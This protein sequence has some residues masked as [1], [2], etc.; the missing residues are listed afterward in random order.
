VSVTAN[1][2]WQPPTDVEQALYEAKSRGDWPGYLDVLGNT[3][4]YYAVERGPLDAVGQRAF[5]SYWNEQTRSYCRSVFTAGM[6][7]A[8]VADPVYVTRSLVALA[9]D[10]PDE[11]TWLLVDPG[12]PCEAFFPG[13]MAHRAIWRQHGERAWTSQRNRLRT[14]SVG[15]PL[16]GPVAH[17]LACGAL[18]C[19]SNG[20]L[21]NAVAWH[22]TGYSGER[23]RLKDWW[24][25][26]GRSEWSDYQERLLQGEMSSG[27]WEFVLRIRR[28]LARA[29]EDGSVPVSRWRDVTERMVQSIEPKEDDDIGFD[30]EA[31]GLQSLIG[32]IMRY[33]SRFRADGLLGEGEFTPSVLA[34]DYGRASKMARWGLG[35]RFCEMWETEQALVRAG[36]EARTFY[37]SWE[38]F[39]AGYILGRCLHFDDEEFGGWYEDMLT[40]HRILTTDPASPWLNIPFT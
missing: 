20:S 7:P 5:T 26:T 27:A 15:G 33:E 18:L 31:E 21:W 1:A 22:G 8:P 40:A 9:S 24:G 2:A 19:V 38:K 3:W 17:G 39:S 30:A 23:E 29:S 6:L 35:A 28:N 11:E 14:L 16:H 12:S 32:R 37:D 34:W 36:Q 10:W 25:I 13:T 4:L